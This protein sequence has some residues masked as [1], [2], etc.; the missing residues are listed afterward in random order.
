ML[1]RSPAVDLAPG[2]TSR[3]CADA[4]ELPEADVRIAA[5]GTSLAGI[6][7]DATTFELALGVAVLPRAE[8]KLAPSLGEL[9]ERLGPL[10]LCAASFAFVVCG[11]S[12][13]FAF[14]VCGRSKRLV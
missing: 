7:R 8:R 13:S 2:M 14:V 10:S 1:L 12:S 4:S 11:R 6:I 9:D 3:L 5:M